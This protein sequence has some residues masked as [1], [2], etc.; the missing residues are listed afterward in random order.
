[1]TRPQDSVISAGSIRTTVLYLAAAAA[2]LRKSS[3]GEPNERSISATAEPP[4]CPSIASP[5]WR[6][7]CGSSST[8]AA[9]SNKALPCQ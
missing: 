8:T 2:M 3:L 4:Y 1:M 9:A 5:T 7:A 6:G